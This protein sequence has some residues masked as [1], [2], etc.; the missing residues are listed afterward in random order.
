MYVVP[1]I[2]EREMVM[3]EM[4]RRRER[5]FNKITISHQIQM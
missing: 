3:E 1:V 2:E 5:V 4:M